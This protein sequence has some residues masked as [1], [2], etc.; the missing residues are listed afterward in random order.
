MNIWL[1]RSMDSEAAL[2]PRSG[3]VPTL[4]EHGLDHVVILLLLHRALGVRREG[5][6]VLHR[7]LSHLPEVLPELVRAPAPLD[8]LGGVAPVLDEGPS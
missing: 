4:L 5:L 1:V 7:A 2:D 3:K 6:P 8:L